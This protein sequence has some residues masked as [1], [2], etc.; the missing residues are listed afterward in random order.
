M[1]DWTPATTGADYELPYILEPLAKVKDQLIVASKLAHLNATA[2]GD[3]AGDHARA[4]AAYLTGVHPNK[5]AGTDIR[6]GIS[7]D[8]IAAEHLRFATRYPSLEL[9]LETGR[10]AGSCDSGYSCAYSNSISWRTGHTPNPPEGNPRLVFERLFGGRESR[11]NADQREK[12]RAYRGSILD[13]VMEDA[14]NLMGQLGPTD[15]RKMDEYLHAVRQVERQIEFNEE[16]S[17]D[18]A[19]GMELPPS[20]PKD[21]GEYARLMFD[22]QV[23]AYKTDQTRVTTMLMRCEGSTAPTRSR[24][25]VAHA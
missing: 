14:N 11:L 17:L 20:A 7:I 1:P 10:L 8:Q 3:G 18:L 16:R 2:M 12:R 13:Y 22:L 5:T 24:V 21:Y 19:N 6:A 9:T 23:L 25:P 4:S 15:R